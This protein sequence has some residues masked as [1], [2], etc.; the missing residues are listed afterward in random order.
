MPS[1]FLQS[2]LCSLTHSKRC[3]HV[4]FLLSGDMS[5]RVGS[6]IMHIF[7]YSSAS[8]RLALSQ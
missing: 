2:E 6:D 4:A 7:E 8:P 3:G 1:A 5:Y